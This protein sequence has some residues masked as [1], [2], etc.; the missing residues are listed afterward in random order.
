MSDPKTYVDK[1]DRQSVGELTDEDIKV[2]LGAPGSGDN[3]I[4]QFKK[5]RADELSRDDKHK[6][7]VF[8][9]M[10]LMAR[11]QA[12]ELNRATGLLLTPDQDAEY[13][14][15]RTTYNEFPESM[16]VSLAAKIYDLSRMCPNVWRFYA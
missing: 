13:I 9:C 14:Q 12:L 8:A 7:A 3:L 15:L 2:E 4:Q 6:A 5:E 1:S 11:L 10:A 16:K